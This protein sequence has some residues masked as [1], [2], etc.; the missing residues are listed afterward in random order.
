MR[1]LAVA[2]ALMC[3]CSV[4]G[5]AD[6]ALGPNDNRGLLFVDVRQ[7]LRSLGI[8]AANASGD[9]QANDSGPIQAAIDYVARQGGGYVLVPAGVYRVERIDVKPG[10]HLLGCGWD[11]TIFRAWSTALMF[12]PSGGWLENF[13]AYGTPTAEG[14]GENWV[15]GTDGVGKGG[16]ATALLIIG[17]Y[18]GE[19]VHIHNVRAMEARY[20][21]IYTAGTRGLRVT[22]CHFDRAGR[23]V[24]SLV[25]NDEDFLFANCHFGS[26]WG[27][28]H[29]DIEPNW[30][31][32]VRD[33][34][35]LNCTFDGRQAG[36]RNTNTWGAFLIF[37]GH[38]ELESRNITVMGCRFYDI[39][40]RV[41]G[42]FPDV[43]FLYNPVMRGKSRVFIRVKTNP[44][45][46]FR[47]AI[48]RG[49]CFTINGEPAQEINQGVAFTGNSVF[50]DN[51][52]AK[53]N[54]LRGQEA[55]SE[56]GQQAE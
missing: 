2:L 8:W 18:G 15:V 42:V 28:Y 11:Q 55:S 49:N 56:T 53:F 50:E 3:L 22:N 10:V 21:C 26:Q 46:E 19:N 23:N 44:V 36:E 12:C 4:G 25:G 37:C 24:A 54:N 31:K 43:K 20:D 6:V 45:G 30:G 34:V 13:S 38:P 5:R 29:V 48:V 9:G 35:F 7:D 47:D 32:Y 52:P 41:H 27:L 33:G 16:T 51:S 40:V 14:S 17:I 39:S 1:V